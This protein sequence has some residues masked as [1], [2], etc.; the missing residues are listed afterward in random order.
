MVMLMQQTIPLVETTAKFPGAKCSQCPYIDQPCIL[1]WNVEHGELLVIGEAPGTQEVLEGIPFVGQSGMLLDRVIERVGHDPLK[2]AKTNACLCRPFRQSDGSV[3]PSNDALSACRRALETVIGQFRGN[4]LLTLGNTA[5]AAVD[6]LEGFQ[7]SEGITTRR[8]IWHE[9]TIELDEFRDRTLHYLPTLHPAAVL[10]APGQIQKLIDDVEKVYQ[11]PYAKHELLSTPYEIIEDLEQ[12]KE[13][14][15]TLKKSDVVA[16]D[17]E[18]Q[19]L[20]WYSTV[21]KQAARVLCFVF[22]GSNAEIGYI[23]PD[24]TLAQPRILEF[25]QM[26]FDSK[27]VLC[28]NGKFDLIIAKTLGLNIVVGDDTM[29]MHGV[30][31]EGKRGHG[32][33]EL[34]QEQFQI[35]NYEDELLAPIFHQHKMNNDNRDYAIVPREILYQYAAID[36]AATLRL[37]FIFERQLIK[38]NQLRTPYR[39]VLIRGVNALAQIEFNGIPID[40][41]YLKRV[42]VL[43]EKAVDDQANEL[44]TIIEPNI[45][46]KYH[47]KLIDLI[48]RSPTKKFNPNSFT[49]MSIVIYNV[50][51]L[52]LRKPPMKPTTTNTGEECLNILIESYPTHTFLKALMEYRSVE[53]IRSTYSSKMLELVDDQNK[54]HVSYNILGTET[55]RLSAA[56]SMHGIP[57]PEK[58]SIP[59]AKRYGAMIRGSFIAPPNH[60]LVIADYSQAELR[61]FADETHDPFF[62]KAYNDG[63]DVHAETMKIMCKTMNIDFATLDEH[64]AHYK[65]IRTL[66]KNINFGGLLYLGGPQ[67][68]AAMTGLDASLVKQVMEYYYNDLAV[69]RKWQLDQFRFA[70]RHGFVQNRFGR[71]RR[72]ILQTSQNIDEI[73]KASVNAVIQGDASDLTLLSVCEMIERG[74]WVGH[75]VHDSIIVIAPENEAENTAQQMKEIMER[76]GAKYFPSIPWIADLEISEYWYAKRPTI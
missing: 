72:F 37:F 71:K 29:L 40:V 69:A 59:E 62:L 60:K 10:R 57:R 75:T 30:L 6:S 49:Q 42:N 74:M 25:L 67:A 73:R 4:V 39:S 34:S 32:L 8:G 61:C 16:F 12:L 17:T 5:T 55:G 47:Q 23:V 18:T 44:R 46:P 41:D 54:I 68:I 28:H 35:P 38:E 24:S 33:K 66:A 58:E 36:V 52:V 19:H 21:W 76:L 43:V 9:L 31:M 56:D 27:F 53:K 70:K 14:I 20:Q 2:I 63:L 48:K 50:F 45:N 7:T 1:P 22:M 13:M 26:F 3:T 51:G 15:Q 64:S 65:E 11:N